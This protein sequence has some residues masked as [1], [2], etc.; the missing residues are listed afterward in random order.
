MVGDYAKQWVC[1]SEG[2][3]SK[4]EKRG[5]AGDHFL[6]RLLLNKFPTIIA[7]NL[8]ITVIGM[9][10]NKIIRNSFPRRNQL[11]TFVSKSNMIGPKKIRKIIVAKKEMH[12]I[13]IFFVRDIGLLL[14]SKIRVTV[15]SIIQAKISIRSISK[16]YFL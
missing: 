14:S 10:E 1:W 13:I 3:T 5:L 4:C 6:S 7:M 11:G 8:A 2:K 9:H 15:I 16:S 12:P